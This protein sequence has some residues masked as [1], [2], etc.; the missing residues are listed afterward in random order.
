[1]VLFVLLWHRRWKMYTF[2][3]LISMH[4]RFLIGQKSHFRTFFQDHP[5]SAYWRH[6]V[7]TLGILKQMRMHA[8]HA[9]AK[10]R[11][12]KKKF[13]VWP[14]I[15]FSAE[16]QQGRSVYLPSWCG[17][18]LYQEQAFFIVIRKKHTA[19]HRSSSGAERKQ[20][21]ASDLHFSLK[22]NQLYSNAWQQL[23]ASDLFKIAN[24]GTW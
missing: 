9:A 10:C 22:C 17:C 15:Y 13:R 1:M 14:H 3:L 23:T 6:K 24:I 19:V 5:S 7:Y 2:F 18:D 11:Q 16:A 4:S 21:I 12:S 8:S 20:L